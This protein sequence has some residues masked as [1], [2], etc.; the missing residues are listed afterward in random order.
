VASIGLTKAFNFVSRSGLFAMLRRFG[1]TNTLLGNV[2]KLHDGM[3]ATVRVDGSR[4]RCFLI[5][6]GV[7]QGCVP[8]PPSLQ[9]S[10][11]HYS[12]VHMR[13]SLEYYCIVAALG[14]CLVFPA[15]AQDRKW[16]D[17]SFSNCSMRTMLS[18]WQPPQSPFEIS[19]TSSPLPVLNLMLPLAWSKPYPSIRDLALPHK[20]A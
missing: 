9:F 6:P 12:C 17:C 13:H 4:C 7:K 5:K 20:S 19:A 8:F 16:D 10:S 15:F 18:S 3:H 2:L 11:L 14:D 1:Y